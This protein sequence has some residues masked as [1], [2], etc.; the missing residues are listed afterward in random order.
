MMDSERGWWRMLDANLNR[1]GEGL[2][3]VEDWCRFVAD[4]RSLSATTKQ[5]RHDLHNLSQAWPWQ[6]RL[7]ARDVMGD[8]GREIT[9]PSETQR[10]SPLSV[11][12]ANLYRVQQS[13]RVIEEATKL[14]RLNSS[15]AV[16]AL[17]YR[18]YD[19]QRQLLLAAA[20][21]TDAS[22]TRQSHEKD[23]PTRTRL[24]EQASVYVLTDTV[25]TQDDY[26]RHIHEL[27]DAGVDVIQ[28]RDKRLADRELWEVAQWTAA[29][30]ASTP[31]L[32]IVNDRADIAAAVGADGVHVG[33]DELPVEVVRAIVGPA[34]LIGLS[35]HSAEQVQAAQATSANYLGLGPVFP[36]GTKDFA[37][38][39]GPA[40]LTECLSLLE[41]PTFAIGGIQAQNVG[42]VHA[43]GIHR[44][45]VQGA[46]GPGSVS[47]A[48]VQQLRP[49]Q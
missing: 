23:L 24:L 44:V 1:C 43:T 6:S 12:Q 32:F 9:T 15:T 26:Q 37:A 21:D 46:L 8:V 40:T 28:L 31:V 35:T 39:V 5:L 36:S 33:Q 11:L 20:A 47:P 38:H 22:P 18:C 13:L 34:R 42:Q 30:L 10:D 14:L 3:V 4:D 25:G 41:R 27:V 17:R 48:A 45:A 29:T 49:Q 7:A 2:R 16:E 19:L